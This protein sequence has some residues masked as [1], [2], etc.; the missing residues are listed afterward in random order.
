[1]LLTVAGGIATYYLLCVIRQILLPCGRWNSHTFLLCVVMADVIAQ[2]QM[3]WPLH[4]DSV[5]LLVDV[6]PRG[7]DGFHG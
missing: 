5:F 7:A 6:I 3:E 1:M 4:G 2:W